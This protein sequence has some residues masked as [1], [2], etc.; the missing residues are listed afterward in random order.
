M[1]LKRLCFS[2]DWDMDSDEMM[3][4]IIELNETVEK[5]LNAFE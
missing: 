5:C 1:S 4:K 2:G 3:G